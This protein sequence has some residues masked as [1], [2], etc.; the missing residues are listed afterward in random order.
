MVRSVTRSGYLPLRELWPVRQGF[1]GCGEWC[2]SQSFELGRAVPAQG[3]CTSLV[4]K[5]TTQRWGI[6]LAARATE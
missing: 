3:M 2:P 6:S 4:P 1:R 5:S